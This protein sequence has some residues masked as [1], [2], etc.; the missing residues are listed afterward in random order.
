MAALT[1][2][3]GEIDKLACYIA[4]WRPVPLPG[5]EKGTA[6]FPLPF[7]TRGEGERNRARIYLG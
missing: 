5:S 3:A 4:G 7:P 1:L 6:I 2:S